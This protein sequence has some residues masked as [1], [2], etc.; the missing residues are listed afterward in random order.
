MAATSSGLYRKIAKFAK[1]VAR[2]LACAVKEFDFN[3]IYYFKIL[4]NYQFDL[5]RARPAGAS[6]QASALLMDGVAVVVGGWMSAGGGVCCAGACVGVVCPLLD[7]SCFV[8]SPS[9]FVHT[10]CKSPDPIG[11]RKLNHCRPC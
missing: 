4:I 3:F 9:A 5:I 6:Q 2:A 7:Q 11:T 8:P 10:Q 1:L